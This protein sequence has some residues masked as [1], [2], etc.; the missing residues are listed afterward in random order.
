MSILQKKQKT[1]PSKGKKTKQTTPSA[2]V[3]RADD[4]TAAD[5]SFPGVSEGPQHDLSRSPDSVQVS[6][7][8]VGMLFYGKEL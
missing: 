4:A 6:L 5:S 1:G 2:T 3:S 8:A 7:P